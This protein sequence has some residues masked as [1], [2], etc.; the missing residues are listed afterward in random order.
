MEASKWEKLA[1][2]AIDQAEYRQYQA[3]ANSLR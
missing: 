2:S 1:N 3:Y